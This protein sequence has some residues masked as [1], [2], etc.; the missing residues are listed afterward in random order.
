MF[1]WRESPLWVVLIMLFATLVI[2][3]ALLY[4]VWFFLWPWFMRYTPYSFL[5]V[6]LVILMIVAYYSL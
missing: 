3:G 5:I 4:I 1:D 2:V 6:A